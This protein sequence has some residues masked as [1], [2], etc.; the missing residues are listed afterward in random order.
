MEHDEGEILGVLD[1]AGSP[2][3]EN[4]GGSESSP[5]VPPV[6]PSGIATDAPERGLIRLVERNFVQEELLALIEAILVCEDLGEMINLLSKDQAQTFVDVMDEALAQPDLPPWTRA[7]YLKQQY[8]TCGCH[9]ILPTALK[10]PICYD[11]TE[12]PLYQGGYGDV[13]KSKYFGRDVAVK[14]IRTYSN[15]NLQKVVGRFCREVV[16]WKNLQHPNVLPLI[17]VTMTETQFAM[18]SDW[19]AN[20]NINEFTEKNP[21]A[22]RLELLKG[23]ARGL[24][25]IHCQGMVHG[26]LKGA[27]ILIDQTGNARL[28]DFGFLT[29]ISD[30]ANLLFSSSCVQGG[31]TTRWMSPELLCPEEFGLKTGRPTKS[32]DCYS[33]GMV[34][35]ETISGNPPFHEDTDTA[36]IVKVLKGERPRR[37]LAF[38]GLWEMLQECW[39]AEPGERPSIEVVLQHLDA[40]SISSTSRPMDG[41]MVGSVQVNGGPDLLVVRQ[42]KYGN[43]GKIY[44]QLPDI[45]FT[46]GNK[47]GIKLTDAL[48]TSFNGLDS[49]DELMFDGDTR[50][51]I[52]CRINFDGFGAWEKAKQISTKN[53]QRKRTSIT[54]KKLGHDVAKLVRTYLDDLERAGCPY[55]IPFED[56]FLVRL[57]HVAR[58]SWQPE[59]WYQVVP[60]STST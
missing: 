4:D 20:G 55:H 38:E 35:Y 7:R 53:Y 21:A 8:K 50:S 24:I 9:A 58:G 59:I 25:Y 39:V 13:W 12:V 40:C 54:K 15:T 57:A 32:S 2:L 27:N 51:A 6:L 48:D 34:I 36:V 42:I 56:M 18:V 46:V 11:R 30:P 41:G 10:V 1:T 29:I 28:A 3:N 19:M 23:V 14:V 5:Q 16:T 60:G 43:P 45:C 37:T 52:S 44:T 17:G 22:D 33:L 49:R 31:G 47:E 26:D